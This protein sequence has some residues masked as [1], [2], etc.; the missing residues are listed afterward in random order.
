MSKPEDG[1]ALDALLKTENPPY[2]QAALESAKAAREFLAVEKAAELL[3]AD[4]EV[5]SKD[6]RFV[7]RYTCRRCRLEF[8][9]SR[10]AANAKFCPR[11]IEES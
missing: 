11:C 7:T 2:V 4:G 5:V 3:K 9:S 8:N 1:D 10:N 6:A